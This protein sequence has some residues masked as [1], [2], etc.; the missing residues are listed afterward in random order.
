MRRNT[1]SAL[2]IWRSPLHRPLILPAQPSIRFQSSANHAPAHQQDHLVGR[3][4]WKRLRQSQKHSLGIDALGKPGEIVVVPD[5][6]RRNTRNRRMKPNDAAGDTERLTLG[7]MLDDLDEE[8]SQLTASAVHQGFEAYRGGCRPNDTLAPGE[9]EELRFKVA[10]SFTY[11]QLSDYLA[12]SRSKLSEIDETTGRWRPG[13]SMF[14]HTTPGGAR[15]EV[16]DR[17]A[18]S[19]DL[20]G[21]PL[22]AEQILRNCWQLSITDEVGQLDLQL[23]SAFV[24]LLLNAEHFSF[25]EVASLHGSS[26]D[27]TSSLGLVRITG[28]QNACESIR[29]VILDATARIREQDVDIEV[30]VDTAGSGQVFGSEFLEWVGKTYGVAFDRGSS[31][32]PEK[33]VYLA[34]NE[35]GADDARRTLNLAVNETRPTPVPFSSYM[36]ASEQASV[37]HFDPEANASWFD[38]QMSWF[39]WAMS[40]VQSV[41]AATPSSP[42]FDTHQTRLSTALLKLLRSTRPPKVNFQSSSHVHESV[43]AAAGRCL[44]ARKGPSEE[45]VMTAPQLGGLSLPRT[46]TTEIPRIAPFLES[47]TPIQPKEE[48]RKYNIRMT[49]SARYAGEVPQLDVEVTFTPAENAEA[50]DMLEVQCVKSIFSTNSVD[51]LLPENGLDL[52]FT[53][54]VYRKVSHETLAGS[55]QYES[56]VQSIKESLRDVLVSGNASRGAVPL[57]AFCQISVPGDLRSLHDPISTD[58]TTAEYLLPPL[59]DIRGAMAQQYDFDGRPLTY[60]FYES[61][62]FLAARTTELLLDME[63]P[64][65]ASDLEHDRP[66]ESVENDFHAFYNAACNMAF[67]IHKAKYETLEVV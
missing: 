32:V 50:E 24:V 53:R 9:W 35:R 44:F 3:R 66:Q 38:R 48:T 27:I 13:T 40:S 54:T 37:Y 21:K 58:S 52:R 36:P 22:L 43:T 6:S 2:A 56:L 55:S 62:P 33:I 42:F 31:H 23:P 25:D 64:G 46:F 14:L 4:R 26:I 61:G 45:T 39:R 63:L 47:L 18:T 20:K 16:T 49:P 17:V 51:Y 57:P 60:R 28:K 19:R 30:G 15:D 12:D 5:S 11:N 7:S 8:A 1:Q 59:S 67:R 29:E 10:S 65:P 34:E 41:E